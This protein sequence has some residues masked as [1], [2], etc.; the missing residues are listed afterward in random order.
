MWIASKIK[1]N[2]LSKHILPPRFYACWQKKEITACVN[3]LSSLVSVSSNGRLTKNFSDLLAD[4]DALNKERALVSVEKSKSIRRLKK[5]D[6][7]VAFVTL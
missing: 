7:T 4:N 2:I 6:I 5:V 3:F 1:D